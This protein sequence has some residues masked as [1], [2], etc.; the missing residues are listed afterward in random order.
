MTESGT[1]DG[2]LASAESGAGEILSREAGAGLGSGSLVSGV[3]TLAGSALGFS[4]SATPLE[5]TF[6]W[7]TLLFASEADMTASFS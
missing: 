1:V 2:D 6:V 3:F 4:P 7:F 5:S